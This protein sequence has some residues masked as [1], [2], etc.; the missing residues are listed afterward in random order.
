MREAKRSELSVLDNVHEM[1]LASSAQLAQV[2]NSLCGRACVCL[3]V[4]ACMCVYV[5]VCVCGRVHVCECECVRACR[6]SCMF[7]FVP[8]GCNAA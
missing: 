2:H 8:P 3:C 7:L 6:G 4:G 1:Q 5:C